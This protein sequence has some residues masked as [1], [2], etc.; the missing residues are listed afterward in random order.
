MKEQNIT[1]T[2][3][4]QDLDVLAMIGQ[5][6][7]DEPTEEEL[8]DIELEPDEDWNDEDAFTSAGF[9]MDESYGMWSE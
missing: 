8:D 6:D 5:L 7:P 1:V 4:K 2:L 9:G 3:T